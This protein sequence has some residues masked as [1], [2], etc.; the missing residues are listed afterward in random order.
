MFP[1][2][3][4]NPCVVIFL[5]LKIELE[6]NADI[7][8]WLRNAGGERRKMVNDSFPGLCYFMSHKLMVTV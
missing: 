8:T 3:L 4:V 1:K 5:Q 2:A 7:E 6:V